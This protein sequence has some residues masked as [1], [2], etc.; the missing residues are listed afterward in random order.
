MRV[1]KSCFAILG[2]VAIG[3]LLS[4]T[5]VLRA[6]FIQPGCGGLECYDDSDCGSACTCQC[7]YCVEKGGTSRLR[8]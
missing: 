2:C 8:Q 4:E 7:S 6:G 5:Y 1:F 3:L